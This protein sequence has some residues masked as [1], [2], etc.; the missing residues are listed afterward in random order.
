MISNPTRPESRRPH[1]RPL[2][3]Y[4]WGPDFRLIKVSGFTNLILYTIEELAIAIRDSL[5]KELATQQGQQLM[6]SLSYQLTAA[7]VDL[8][9]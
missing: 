3:F 1:Y 6:A 2:T 7:I 4:T 9:H 5:I 8:T